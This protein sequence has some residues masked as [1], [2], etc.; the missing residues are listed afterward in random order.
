[1]SFP[2]LYTILTLNVFTVVR[3]A[4]FLN[5]N[6]ISLA[7]VF[8]ML[9]QLV[10]CHNNG[11][12][13]VLIPSEA[14]RSVQARVWLPNTRLHMEATSYDYPRDMPKKTSVVCLFWSVFHDPYKFQATPNCFRIFLQISKQCIQIPASH[15]QCIY[16]TS[17]LSACHRKLASVSR[18]RFPMNYANP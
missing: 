6:W 17:Y 15:N 16:I 1:M 7:W 5:W 3:N 18:K 10:N 13:D 4:K 9:G 2:A 8:R 12:S 11:L 14:G